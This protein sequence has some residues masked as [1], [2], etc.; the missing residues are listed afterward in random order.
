MTRRPAL[1]EK[2]RP[3]QLAQRRRDLLRTQRCVVCV[4]LVAILLLLI[5]WLGTI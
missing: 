5:W 2:H 1:V 4:A 3:V